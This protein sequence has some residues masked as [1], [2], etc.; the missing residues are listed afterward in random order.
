MYKF[1]SLFVLL[2]L[3]ISGQ[4]QKVFP[5]L[6]LRK[7]VGI[8]TQTFSYTGFL[9]PF[10][11]PNRVTS[12]QVNAIGA[13]GGTGARGQVGGAGANITSTLNVTPG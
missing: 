5:A 10:I 4:A 11:V 6:A 2:I 8:N 12:I 3:S 7:P 13:K 9:Q 1:L